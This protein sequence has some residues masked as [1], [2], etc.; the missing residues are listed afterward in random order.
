MRTVKTGSSATAV[1]IVH[2]S[3][4]GSRGI[5]HIGSA[6]DDVQVDALK[7]TA[8]QRLTAGQGEFAP[9]LER[10]E[11][12]RRNAGDPLPI[13][14]SRMGHLLD[15][16]KHVYRVLGFEDVAC[17]DEVFRHLML[18]RIIEPASKLDSLR[19]LEEADVAA[20]F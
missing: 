12:A 10:T 16:L 9:V 4:R 13:T 20:A 11:P 2:P 15:A 7:A 1:Q 6:L 5:E 8:H 14:T 18:A 3:R 17:G 19:V